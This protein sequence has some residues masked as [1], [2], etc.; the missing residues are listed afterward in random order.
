MWTVTHCDSASYREDS[1]PEPGKQADFWRRLGAEGQDVV[2]KEAGGE[3]VC[4]GS[5]G[6]VRW[7]RWGRKD[8][9]SVFATVGTRSGAG[10]LFVSGTEYQQAKFSNHNTHR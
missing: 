6:G 9:V 5:G 1:Q 10:T 4:G 7:W 2:R 8:V 3:S